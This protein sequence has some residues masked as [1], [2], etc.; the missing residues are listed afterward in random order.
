MRK[1]MAI[2]LICIGL[3][4]IL[5]WVTY[6]RHI[7]PPFFCEAN[8][9]IVQ[10]INDETIL[11]DGLIT[12]EASG[13]YL[14]LNIDGLMTRNK[15]KYIISRSMQIEYKNHSNNSHFYRIKNISI[16]RYNADNI[17]DDFASDLLFS[18]DGDTQ[19]VYIKKLSNN[20]LLFGNNLF[21]KYGCRKR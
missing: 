12:L 20:M 13:K 6:T 19:L 21:P 16:S 1:R 4:V 2:I 3:T 11:A 9:S 17:D 8:F 7:T 5:G 14:F 18:H 15:K 10:K